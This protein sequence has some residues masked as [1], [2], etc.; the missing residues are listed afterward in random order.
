MTSMANRSTDYRTLVARKIAAREPF[1][2][3]RDE[4][5][6]FVFFP[7]PIYRDPAPAGGSYFR[8]S[9]WDDG[10]KGFPDTDREEY[11]EN[12]RGLMSWLGAEVPKTVFSRTRTG[13]IALE[14]LADRVFGYFLHFPA[15][16]CFFYYTPETGYWFGATPEILLREDAPGRYSTMALAG[17]REA[18]VNS[19]WD[20]KNIAEHRFV[21]DFIISA[22]R[23]AGAEVRSGE[24]TSLRYGTIEHLH[25]PIAVEAPSELF[26]LLGDSLNPTPALCGTPRDAARRLIDVFEPH[27]RGCYGG[28]IEFRDPVSGLRRAYVNLRCARMDL[29]GRWCA[30]AGGGIVESSVPEDEWEETVRK[31]SPIVQA[32]S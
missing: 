24:M 11:L 2:L 28:Y 4:A 18:T 19:P 20:D 23:E 26:P 10:H 16:L 6:R 13:R 32:L 12:L 17:T 14:S 21:V 5:G 25:T 29:L 8:I 31:I 30:F 15:S 9:P 3:V 27:S 1:A 22:L 7:K